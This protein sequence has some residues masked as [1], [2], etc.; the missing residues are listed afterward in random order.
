MPK[1]RSRETLYTYKDHCFLCGTEVET[2]N[3]TDF[4]FQMRTWQYK[5]R[6]LPHV[7]NV[8]MM[9]NGLGLFV[10]ASSL[11]TIFQLQMSYITE[12]AA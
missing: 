8:V 11:F 5:F 1:L 4:I 7:S 3:K 9:K 2:E 12:F 10:H 6:I